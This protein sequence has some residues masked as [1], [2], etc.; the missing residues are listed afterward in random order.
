MKADKSAI[1]QEHCTESDTSKN[2]VHYI[3]FFSLQKTNNKSRISMNLRMMNHSY[4]TSQVFLLLVLLSQT[5]ILPSLR[6]FL[7]EEAPCTSSAFGVET[8]TGQKCHLSLQHRTLLFDTC[9]MGLHQP[10]CNASILV[11]RN[12]IALLVL[13]QPSKDANQSVAWKFS[14][15]YITKEGQ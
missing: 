15:N 9:W 12:P 10:F 5:W 7:Q 14:R 11:L 1:Q 13:L 3:S 2:G 6:G 4:L 8:S